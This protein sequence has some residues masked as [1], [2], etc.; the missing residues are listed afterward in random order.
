MIGGMGTPG[1][2]EDCGVV[3][4]KTVAGARTVRRSSDSGGKA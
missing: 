4:E 2:G 1:S 3:V